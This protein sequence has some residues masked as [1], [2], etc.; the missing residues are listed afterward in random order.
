MFNE[1][2]DYKVLI[3]CLEFLLHWY[4]IFSEEDVK[5]M[6]EWHDYL[7]NKYEKVK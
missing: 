3:K 4:D 1:K 5:K 7:F 2:E 6:N